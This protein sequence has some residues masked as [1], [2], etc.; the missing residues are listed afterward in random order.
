MTL[1]FSVHPDVQV[2]KPPAWLR[3]AGDNL[4]LAMVEV[5]PFSSLTKIRQIPNVRFVTPCRLPE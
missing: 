5:R 3:I 4:R 1:P 2:A